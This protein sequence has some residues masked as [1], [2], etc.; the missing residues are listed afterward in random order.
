MNITEKSSTESKSNEQTKGNNMNTTTK[1]KKSYFYAIPKAVLTWAH[2]AEKMPL[3]KTKDKLE[4]QRKYTATLL[5]S[6]S[7]EDHIK[8]IDNMRVDYD[9]L[10]GEYRIREPRSIIKDGDADYEYEINEENKKKLEYKVGHYWIRANN[11]KQPN[12]THKDGSPLI[13]PKDNEVLYFGCFVHAY[14]EMYPHGMKDNWDKITGV[15]FRLHHVQ[16]AKER[17][18]N[19]GLSPI[20][21][22]AAFESYIENEDKEEAKEFAEGVIPNAKKEIDIY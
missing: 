16:F 21:G 5:L 8:I 7:N 6:K 13:F 19:G 4:S 1:Q 22:A 20:S 11:G 12:L 9:S 10:I 3:E 14:V 17:G 18:N 15:A 2:L